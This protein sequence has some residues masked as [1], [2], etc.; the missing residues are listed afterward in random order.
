MRKVILPI[1]PFIFI[2]GMYLESSIG[3]VNSKKLSGPKDMTKSSFNRW[4]SH[5][6]LFWNPAVASSKRLS[7]YP[8]LTTCLRASSFRWLPVGFYLKTCT[9][10]HYMF[11]VKIWRT[12]VY[13]PKIWHFITTAQCNK[14]MVSNCGAVALYFSI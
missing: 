8:K 10:Y 2:N 14:I 12:L 7:G 13:N 1:H 5:G 6:F 9:I 4:I 3:V 11:L